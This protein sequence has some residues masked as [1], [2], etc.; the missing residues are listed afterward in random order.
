MLLLAISALLLGHVLRAARHALL[1]PKTLP[2]RFDLLLGLT[3]GYAVNTLL[4]FRLGE[5][6]RIAVVSYRTRVRTSYVAATVAAERLTDLVAVAG[7]FLLLSAMGEGLTSE[8][9]LHAARM[10]ILSLLIVAFAVAIGHTSWVRRSVWSVISIFND[11]IAGAL[12]DFFLSF[13]QLVTQGSLISRRYIL[14]SV[15]MWSC[16]TSAYAF[17]ALYS[18]AALSNIFVALLG[19]PQRAIWQSAYESGI[20]LAPF[21]APP[22]VAV[23]LY[24][25]VRDSKGMKI[26]RNAAWRLGLSPSGLVRPTISHAFASGNDYSLLLKAH[27]THTEP[28]VTA[29]GFQGVDRAV[30]HRIL[31]GGSDA[32]TAVVEVDERF[33]IRKFA[34]GSAGA[35]LKNQSDWLMRYEDRL[36]LPPVTDEKLSDASFYYDM[37]YI[38]AARDFYEHIH[39]SPLASSK[40]IIEQ[41]VESMEGFH[42]EHDA[43]AADDAT[44]DAY[45]SGKVVENARQILSYMSSRIPAR[46]LINQETHDLGEWE[47]LTDLRWLRKQI[48][49]PRTS[50]IHGDLTIENI[51]VC[52]SADKGWYLIDPNPDNIFNT[53]FIDWAKMYQSLNLGYETMNRGGSA[54]LTGDG[55]EVLFSRSHAYE[56][57][58]LFF[59]QLATEKLTPEQIREVRFHEL[60]NYLR[61]TPYKMRQSPSKALLFFCC[62]SILLKRYSESLVDA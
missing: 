33:V 52:P 5:L 62:S 45:L 16:Y 36:P 58:Q 18:D 12:G 13:S 30:V 41:V 51:I 1:F 9:L 50:T 49:T 40:A 43:G 37:P 19:L 59:D 14:L 32:V 31:P 10:A 25:L 61:L 4:P 60:V 56:Q 26:Q 11:R 38:P 20:Q 47:R 53:P 15:V 8:F 42:A 3:V 17:F 46:Y 39:T 24:G 27:F 21:I 55:V 23:L 48:H 7:F 57:L 44:I 2:G 28:A 35:K 54:K 22:V 29:F 6:L 34:T